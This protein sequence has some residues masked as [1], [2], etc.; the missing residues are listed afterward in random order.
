MNNEVPPVRISAFVGRSFLPEDEPVWY[1][2]RNILES[3]RPMGFKFE[4]A[5]EAQLRPISE[6]VRQGI[7]RNDFY[8]GI[9]T[10]RFPITD[11]P[12][13]MT[14]V[15]RI[16]SDIQSVKIPSGW[17][18][19]DW[20]VQ[21]SG[22]ALGKGKKVLFLIEEGV[23]F[24]RSDLSADTEWISFDRSA[25][26]QCTNRLVSMIGNLIAEK[27]PAVPPTVQVVS[28]E[29]PTPEEQPVEPGPTGNF[30]QVMEYLEQGKLQQADEAFE[31]FIE[32]QPEDPLNRW[33]RYFY[34]R[35]KSIKGD[36]GSL[37]Q[38]K[39]IVEGEPQNVQARVE[40][41]RYYRAFKQHSAAARI[42]IEGVEVSPGQSLPRLLRYAAEEFAKDNQHEKSIK[43]IADLLPLLTDPDEV[44][45]TFLSLADIAKSQSNREL[46]SAALERVLDLDPS[47]STVRFRLAY[48]Y[49]EM[50]KNGLSIY[51]YKLRLAQGRDDT[52]LNNLG[53]AFQTLNL[54]GNEVETYE[55]VSSDYWLARANLSH[56]YVDRGFLAEGDELALEVTRADCDETARNRATSALRR[57]ATM[58]ST[59]KE[60]EEKILA[61][62]KAE[63]TFRSAYAEAFG[64]PTVTPINGLFDTRHGRISFRQEGDRLLGQ[65]RIEEQIPEALD[66]LGLRLALPASARVKVKALNF[67]ANIVGRS[68][69][70]KLE[71]QEQEGQGPF[72][73]PKFSSVKGLVILANDGQSF[74]VLEDQESKVTIYTATRVEVS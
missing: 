27:L 51:H 50:N 31:R 10:R 29:S 70:F 55:S 62:A 37:E 57:I 1:E 18:T 13:K 38:L 54:P 58:R 42:L 28:P 74:E 63:R 73:F 11:K 39:S 45:Q 3:L 34:L 48:L 14:I 64:S 47:D 61:E 33:F 30:K 56:A 65:A 2:I 19:S 26:S 9:L 7:E 6:K 5:K 8:I 25:L 23:N 72:S 68:G 15:R 24:P 52:A 16:F 12:T 46:E 21:E 67:D 17:T 49:S 71:I 66:L 53:V 35:Q 60:T 20:V 41:A 22:F 44:R 69:R 36:P 43:T 59:E 40:L 32:S 4:D